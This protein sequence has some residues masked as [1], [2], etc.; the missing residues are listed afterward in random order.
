MEVIKR[1]KA[2]KDAIPIK[3]GRPQNTQVLKRHKAS[4]DARPQIP[5]ACKNARSFKRSKA[6][7]TDTGPK[8][9]MASSDAIHFQKKN[10]NWHKAWTF[11]YCYAELHFVLL[12][13][14]K[15]W[16]LLDLFASHRLAFLLHLD[17]GP[18]LAL[19]QKVPGDTIKLARSPI[20]QEAPQVPWGEGPNPG[21]Q[22]TY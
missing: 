20:H 7:K 18:L 19:H 2:S 10:L 6:F 12:I 1:H 14:W 5:K 11:I 15:K 3:D 4:E 16:W 22:L 13:E 21:Q 9:Y 17:C 8:L